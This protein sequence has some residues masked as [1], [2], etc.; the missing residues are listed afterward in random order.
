MSESPP[1]TVGI[2]RNGLLLVFA[3]LL[4]VANLVL[5]AW[6]HLMPAPGRS[7]QQGAGVQQ[8]IEGPLGS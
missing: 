4:L 2:S 3:L 6:L 1:Q 7:S 5:L 8:V